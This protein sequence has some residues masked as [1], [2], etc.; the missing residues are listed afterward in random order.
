MVPFPAAAKCIS[1]ILNQRHLLYQFSIRDVQ[2]QYRGSYLGVFWTILNPLLMLG[3]YTFVFGYVF[4]GSF[5]DET[6]IEHA[7]GIFIGLTIHSFLAEVMAVGPTLISS[8]ST[9]VKKVVF[10]LE[11]LVASKVAA[12]L[13]TFC[14]KVTIILIAAQFLGFSMTLNYLGIIPLFI[15]LIILTFGIGLSFAS[16]GVFIKDL[17]SA[18]QFISM[19]LLFGSAVFYPVSKIPEQAWNFL[20]FNPLV[21]IIN[22]TREI[23]LWNNPVTTQDIAAS[24]SIAIFTFLIGSYSFAKLKPAFADVI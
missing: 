3:I 2:L 1:L 7:L 9:F 6:P 18:S 14:I 10:P 21:Y 12:S 23:I 22:R 16:I 13:L 19:S 17:G 11:I 4:G 8:N 15:S 5:A 20:K 24:A